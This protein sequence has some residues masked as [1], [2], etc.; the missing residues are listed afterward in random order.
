[1][2][3]FDR[4]IDVASYLYRVEIFV[5]IFD[6]F[7]LIAAIFY[8][9][10]IPK[11]KTLDDVGRSRFLKESE[12]LWTR[13]MIFVLMAGTWSVEFITWKA[14]NQYEVFLIGDAL[15]LL[16]SSTIFILLITKSN[17]QVAIIKLISSFRDKDEHFSFSN[18]A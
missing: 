4:F 16:C 2:T 1:M 3:R 9:Y 7:C 11:N 10:Y 12:W 13:T 18:P 15:K 5:G 14:D 8:I 6:G 17:V